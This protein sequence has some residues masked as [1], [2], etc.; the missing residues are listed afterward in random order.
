[1]R[2]LRTV[3]IH[4]GELVGREGFIIGHDADTERSSNKIGSEGEWVC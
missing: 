4:G 3:S 1:M 2:V